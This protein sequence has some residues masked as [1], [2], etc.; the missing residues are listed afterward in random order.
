MNEHIAEYRAREL[1][2]EVNTLEKF[3]KT[4]SEIEYL[5]DLD[6]DA[7]FKAYESVISKALE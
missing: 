1:L 2:A 4:F 6:L 5:S 3:A 7:I